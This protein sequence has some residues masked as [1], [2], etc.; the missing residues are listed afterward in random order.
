MHALIFSCSLHH[1]Y[2]KIEKKKTTYILPLI[3]N[4]GDNS[5]CF[6]LFFPHSYNFKNPKT[7]DGPFIWK[8]TMDECGHCSFLCIVGVGVWSKFEVWVM[9]LKCW[10]TFWSLCLWRTSSLLAHGWNSND[11]LG[12][13]FCRGLGLDIGNG[14]DLAAIRLPLQAF[15][16]F[17]QTWIHLQND[18][19]KTHVKLNYIKLIT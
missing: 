15:H 4:K 16:E 5:T 17:A 6:F 11:S 19:R 9:L 13:H 7:S 3:N 12:R 2:E 10:F 14:R 1:K 18:I 8:G